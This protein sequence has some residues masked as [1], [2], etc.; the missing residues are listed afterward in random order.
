MRDEFVRHLHSPLC[1]ALLR[2]ASPAEPPAYALALRLLT[3]LL[4]QPKLRRGLKVR[5]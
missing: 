1:L 5:L 4:L 2:N 3:A